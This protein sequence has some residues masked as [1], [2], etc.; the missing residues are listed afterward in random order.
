MDVIRVVFIV[1]SEDISNIILVFPLFYFKQINADWTV[2][3][4]NAVAW[5]L[6]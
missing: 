6:N 3:F 5:M 2:N 1:K 4:I